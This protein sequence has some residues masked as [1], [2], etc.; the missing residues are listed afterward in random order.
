MMHNYSYTFRFSCTTITSQ[1]K[2]DKNTE[3]EYFYMSLRE[4]VFD[5]Y[6]TFSKRLEMYKDAEYHDSQDIYAEFFQKKVHFINM[7]EKGNFSQIFKKVVIQYHHAV[8]NRVEESPVMCPIVRVTTSLNSQISISVW[9]FYEFVS[10]SLV[11]MIWFM[12]N[13]IYSIQ[14]LKIAN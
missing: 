13:F 6:F 1:E 10:E 11:G 8:N 12:K 14:T 2:T 7:E 3:E 4:E 5:T 9:L